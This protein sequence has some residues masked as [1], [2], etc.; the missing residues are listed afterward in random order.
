MVQLSEHVPVLAH[1]ICDEK[2]SE[3]LPNN[4]K[5]IYYEYLLKIINMI[6]TCIKSQV[7]IHQSPCP[8]SIHEHLDL[9]QYLII[10]HL[11]VQFINPKPFDDPEKPQSIIN[12]RE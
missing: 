1:V 4:L 7:F 12:N 10:T 3:K 6:L 8:V 11:M 5:A 2:D 9:G